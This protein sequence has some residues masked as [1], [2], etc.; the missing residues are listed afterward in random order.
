MGCVGPWVRGL[1]GSDFYVGCVGDVGLNIFYV[2]HNF[3]V[4]CV[5]QIY[6]CVG[7]SFLRGSIFLCESTFLYELKRFCEG[8]SFCV[9][10]WV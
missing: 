1:R 2:G 6:F 9:G 5:G 3:Y 10:Q 7:Q 8:P 4:G